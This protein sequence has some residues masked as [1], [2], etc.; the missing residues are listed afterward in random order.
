MIGARP[1]LV[2]D[3]K[4]RLRQKGLCEHLDENPSHVPLHSSDERA[5]DGQNRSL[6]ILV[7]AIDWKLS[8]DLETV[9][10]PLKLS[11][12]AKRRFVMGTVLFSRFPSYRVTLAVGNS[13]GVHITGIPR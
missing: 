10:F 3:N 6:P 8:L 7:L 1:L 13:F 2:G 4:L 5:R 12:H 11:T 9:V